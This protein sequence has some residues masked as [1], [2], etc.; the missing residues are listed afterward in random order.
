MSAGEGVCVM[1]VC[2]LYVCVSRVCVCVYF[3]ATTGR[4]QL[5]PNLPLIFLPEWHLN[6]LCYSCGRGRFL[7]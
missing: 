7:W 4:L 2:V 5:T 1:G 6:G 3:G